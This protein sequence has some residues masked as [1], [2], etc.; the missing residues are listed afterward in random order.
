M[1][2]PTIALAKRLLT[3]T[4]KA[5]DK[6]KVSVVV[7]PPSIFLRELAGKSRGTRVTFALQHGHFD[8]GGAHTGEISMQQAKDAKASYVLIGHAERRARGESNED[9]KKK[10]EAA[11]AHGLIPV[12]CVG[13]TQRSPNGEYFNLIAEQL[14]AALSDLSAAQLL[15][16]II[17]Y[18]PLWT[19]GTDDTMSP[20]DMHEMAI[21]I[22]KTIVNMRGE[23]G[24]SMRILYGGSLNA[25]N[26][27]AMLREGDI[28]G[29]LVGR[30][31]W[32]AVEF[33]H[34]LKAVGNA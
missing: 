22:R 34:L 18:E 32:D 2:P 30:A 16:S 29:L 27:S 20:R 3:D 8:E 24:H 33:A 12:L 5:A 21:F 26:T 15:R 13:E 28:H 6:H 17:V 4:R 9:T 11:H 23:Q 7:A 31:S 10:V 1:N 19:I 25:E 14:R